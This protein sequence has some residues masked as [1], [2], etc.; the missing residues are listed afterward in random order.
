MKKIFSG[1]IAVALF[2]TAFGQ[3]KKK[4]D[5]S[6]VVLDRAGDHF[7]IQGSWDN[8]SNA[9]DSIKNLQSGFSRGFNVAIMLN[10]PFKGDPRW[11]VALG[12]G[13]SNSNI[14]FKNT[15]IDLKSTSIR[16]PFTN[17]TDTNHFK[18]YKLANTYAE[19][20]IELRYT[21]DPANQK[22]SYKLALGVK[23]GYMI[24][25]HT[26]GKILQTKNDVTINEYTEKINKKNYFNN[27]RLAGTFRAG[28]GNF[29]VFGSY[30]ITTLLKDVAGA[31]IRPYQIGLCISGL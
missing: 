17:V 12:V 10:K 27:T 9:P 30:A 15:T 23:V 2:G 20:P 19:A 18:K 13:V 29:S 14:F 26:K 22:K 24:N 4:E 6:K 8:W 31:P 11:S 7:M 25:A 5:W 16:L 1:I 28:I 3:E 21:F